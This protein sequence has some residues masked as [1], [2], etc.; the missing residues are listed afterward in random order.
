MHDAQSDTVPLQSIYGDSKNAGMVSCLDES[1]VRFNGGIV[2]P[3]SWLDE[4]EPSVVESMNEVQDEL[5]KAKEEAKIAREKQFEREQNLRDVISQYK[6]LQKEHATVSKAL[7]DK[8]KLVSASTMTTES[9]NTDDSKSNVDSEN[10]YTEL[11]NEHDTTKEIIQDM[12]GKITDAQEAL[13]MAR[14]RR[15]I[16]RL[17]NLQHNRPGDEEQ[18]ATTKREAIAHYKALQEEFMSALQDKKELEK[19]L[20]DQDVKLESTLTAPR[21]SSSAMAQDTTTAEDDG[22]ADSS[23]PP[24]LETSQ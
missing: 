9:P 11:V 4:C 17:R 20:Y 24:Q 6:Q 8:E 5:R 21:P 13:R 3:P 14:E 15:G 2:H 22:V 23:I 16:H 1:S 7:R 12:R 10:L 19:V 18:H